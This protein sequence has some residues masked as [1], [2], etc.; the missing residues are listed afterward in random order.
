VALQRPGEF[1]GD[2]D[3]SEAKLLAANTHIKFTNY[4]RGYVRC[5]LTRETCRA[6]FR[7]LPSVTTPRG[8]R[9]DTHLL[10]DRSG[11]ARRA[12]R[13]IQASIAA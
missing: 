11:P 6:D 12:A 8:A 2:L 13:L 5:S 1:R 4:Q 10:R 7:V 9:H 3:P